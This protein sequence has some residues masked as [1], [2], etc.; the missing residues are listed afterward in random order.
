MTPMIDVTFL[1]IVF[2]VLVS[3]IV[4]VEN[5]DMDLPNPHDPKTMSMADE[6]RV[7]INV[8]PADSGVGEIRHYKIGTRVFSPTEDG[9]NAMIEH[10]AA[11]YGRD[12]DLN[13][14]LRADR[15]THYEWVEPAMQAITL[16]ASRSGNAEIAPRINL[17]VLRDQR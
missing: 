12:P 9:V 6:H 16:A 14:N 1:L 15:A 8:E 13:I 7:I 10:L 3:Q 4:D 11:M 2:F 17:V 5:V